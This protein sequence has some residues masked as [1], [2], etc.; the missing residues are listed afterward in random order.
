MNSLHT[1]LATSAIAL[2]GNAALAQCLQSPNNPPGAQFPI[3]DDAVRT[4]GLP[5][6]FPFHGGTTN[7]ITICSNGFIWLGTPPVTNATDFSPTQAELLAGPARVCVDWT[8]WDTD[9]PAIPPGGGVFF[10]ATYSYASIVWK[11]IPQ[12]GSTTIFANMECVLTATG[13]IHLFYATNHGT[14]SVP[15]IVGFSRGGAV[16]ANV[17]DWAPSM[18]LALPDSN[19]H[20]VFTGTPGANPFDIQGRL[21]NIRPA[22]PPQTTTPVNFTLNGNPLPVCGTVFPMAVAPVASGTGCPTP[23]VSLY[24]FYTGTAGARPFDLANTSVLFQRS[25]DF[26]STAAGP[27]F[28]ANY[29]TSG[30]VEAAAADDTLHTYPL[31]TNF[32]FGNTS[33]S[34]VT[35]SSNGYLWFG[36]STSQQFNASVASFHSATL[37]RV[38]V[39]WKDLVPNNTTVPIYVENNATRFM[40]TWQA[41]PMF[42]V[43]GSAVT[44]QVQIVH[45]TGDI[46]VS[47][48]AVTGTY[49]TNPPLVGIA[50]AAPV[51]NAGNSDLATSSVVNVLGPVR[52]S[53][54]GQPLQ[55]NVAGLGAQLGQN[56]VMSFVG[57]PPSNGGVATFVVGSQTFNTSIDSITS[58]GMAPGCFIYTDTID[59]WPLIQAPGLPGG[60]VTVPVP[61]DPFMAGVVLRSQCALIAPVNPLGGITS[62]VQTWTVGF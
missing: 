12:F 19:A 11:N 10:T 45:A 57:A 27:G 49:T 35:L 37:P 40:A 46:I 61:M 32:S 3:A 47:Y 33:I 16:P 48:G 52:A 44:A 22:V 8:D 28:D 29:A 51:Q 53:N 23:N 34:Q 60:Q 21:I 14:P 1:F 36:S 4:V 58:P 38:S 50:S 6:S 13:G 2:L 24:E 26:Y 41:V 39:F 30:A 59:Q 15:N 9:S 25:G 17:V 62:N 7:L 18:P 43:A 5:F 42:N 20:E 54:G 56:L 55:H 31:T